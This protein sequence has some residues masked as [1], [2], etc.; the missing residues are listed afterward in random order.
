MVASARPFH[1]RLAMSQDLRVGAALG[2]LCFSLS[3][4]AWAEAA[5]R[6]VDA[7]FDEFTRPGTPGCAVAVVH[8]GRTLL[9]KGYGVANLEHDAPITPRTVFYLA[10][11]S[12]HV[13]AMSVA[14][15]V[16]E[17]RLRLQDDVRALL[18]ELPDYGSTITVRH[19]IEHTS[20]LP[21]FVDLWDLMGLPIDG[22]YDEEDVLR[23]L[24]RHPVLT[25]KP[26]ARYSYTNS[27][28]FLL[29][30]IVKRVT[31]ASLRAFAEARL[32]RPLGM[33]RT[34]FHD[35]H[36][37][38]V[39]GRATGYVK[40]GARYRIV[41]PQFNLV[42]SGGLMS[43]IEDLAR[44]E[45]GL[46]D[47]PGQGQSPTGALLAAMTR[48][49][50]GGPGAEVAPGVRY[51]WGMFMG[52]HRGQAALYHV[53]EYEGYRA[54]FLRLPAPRLSV[55]CVCN[56]GAAQPHRL[57][58]EVADIYLDT[59]GRQAAR[60]GPPPRPAAPAP[61]PALA[62]GA[63]P[64]PEQLDACPG[65]YRSDALDVTYAIARGPQGELTLSWP[66]HPPRPLRRT[67]DGA[68]GLADGPTVRCERHE[69]LVSAG[70]LRDLRFTRLPLPPSRPR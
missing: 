61:A 56:N 44:W 24:R 50:A 27:G 16:Q 17:G 52:R 20:G 14:L 9:A 70:A 47:P 69:I 32:F 37:E 3:A 19:L 36:T 64:S 22:V 63:A 67:Q 51:G 60:P 6:R 28:Y 54:H 65:R 46:Q 57:A 23:A 42:G 11:T 21:D 8:R 25:G 12:K 18:P 7:L 40:D 55:Y 31:G 10:S 68:L 66:W 62:S 38:V 29:G 58:A 35:D 2:L 45:Q 33:A 49:V 59:L 34:H 48:D 43:T 30:L 13:V 1:Y 41:G 5:E 53:G 4:V 39:P 15:L 26:G